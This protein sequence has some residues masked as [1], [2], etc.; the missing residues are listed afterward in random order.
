MKLVFFTEVHD[1]I[2]Y[3]IV[4]L[5][6]HEADVGYIDRYDDLLNRLNLNAII[7]E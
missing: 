1:K 7:I 4:C 3:I 2:Q 6:S 5:T